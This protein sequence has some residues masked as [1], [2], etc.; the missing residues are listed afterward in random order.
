MSSETSF[1]MSAWVNSFLDFMNKLQPEFVE[2]I[3]TDLEEGKLYVSMKYCTAVH[4]CACGCGERVVTPLREN[5]WTL[6][7]NGVVTLSPSIGNFEFPCRSHYYIIRNGIQW[8]PSDVTDKHNK[9][10]KKCKTIRFKRKFPF[11]S[12]V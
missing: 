1:S 2:F 10:P 9:R 4:L 5:E 8:L 3:P 6:S 12:L 11:F 7:F